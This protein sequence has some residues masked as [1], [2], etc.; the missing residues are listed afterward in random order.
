M[1][2]EDHRADFDAL[3]PGAN[4]ADTFHIDIDGDA[5]TARQAAKRMFERLPRWISGLMKLRNLIVAPFGLKTPSH[6][7]STAADSVGAFPVISDTPERL[8]AGF[9]DRHLD[10]RVVVDISGQASRRR[11]AATTLVKTHNRFG[12]IYLA[13][14]MPFHRMI[15]PAMLRRI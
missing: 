1:T 3:L 4:F 15:V 7:T 13:V 6:D 9:D 10:F 5:V 11:V 8:V 12:Q 14:I 2:I